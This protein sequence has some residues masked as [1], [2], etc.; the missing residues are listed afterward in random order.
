MR[1]SF[2]EINGRKC[3]LSDDR[4]WVGEKEIELKPCPCCGCPNLR[5]WSSKWGDEPREYYGVECRG[6]GIEI[7]GTP[8]WAEI[9]N[10]RAYE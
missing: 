7:R 2:V 8:E 9:W 10:R 6:C 3:K 5:L 4:N 1:F